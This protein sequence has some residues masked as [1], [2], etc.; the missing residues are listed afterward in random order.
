[1]TT[2]KRQRYAEQADE[3]LQRLQSIEAEFAEN[4][5]PMFGNQIHE[6]EAYRALFAFGGTLT[7]LEQQ[8]IMSTHDLELALEMDRVL[9][10]ETGRVLF[11]GVPAAAVDM[12][13]ALC[14][15]GL[16]AP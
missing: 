8:I 4:R 12:Y 6:R 16:A 9:V 13:R 11:D 7:G 10:V 1:M 5:V 14:A 15:T 2:E 3:M